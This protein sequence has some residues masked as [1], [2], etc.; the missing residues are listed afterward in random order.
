MQAAPAAAAAAPTELDG[1]WTVDLSTDPAQPY[2]K[3]MHL[4]LLADGTVAGDFYESD[5]QAGRWKRQHGR[6]CVS[7]RTTDGAGPYHTAACAAGDHVEGQTWAEHRNF[8]FI[9]NAAR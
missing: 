7:F 6:L 2:L 1:A 5:I 9:W 8:V 4:T 3:P